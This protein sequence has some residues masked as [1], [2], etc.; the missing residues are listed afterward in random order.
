[1]SDRRWGVK[2]GDSS[3]NLNKTEE[4]KSHKENSQ[5]FKG[6]LQCKLRDI[7]AGAPSKWKGSGMNRDSSDLW[8]RGCKDSGVKVDMNEK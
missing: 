4:I 2:L 1:M 5:R 3:N 7:W 6:H 8:E